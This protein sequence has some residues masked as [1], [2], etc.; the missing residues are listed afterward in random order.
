MADP[1][2][3]SVEATGIASGIREIVI[4]ND[5]REA[6]LIHQPLEYQ[7]GRSLLP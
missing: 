4:G 3:D 5:V 2:S 6:W 1:A 7:S